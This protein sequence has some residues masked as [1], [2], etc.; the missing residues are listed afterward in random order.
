MVVIVGFIRKES[1]K[2]MRPLWEVYIVATSG[3]PTEYE[4]NP[5]PKYKLRKLNLGIIWWNVK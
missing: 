1:V 5:Q 2:I 3:H 4:W